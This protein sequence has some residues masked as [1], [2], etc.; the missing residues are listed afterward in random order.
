MAS[1]TGTDWVE[2]LED[3][4][5]GSDDPARALERVL[6][7]PMIAFML[8]FANALEAV[9]DLFIVPVRSLLDGIDALLGA[10]FGSGAT[11]AADVISAGAQE[12]IRSLRDGPFSVLSFN[13]GV[14]VVLLSG[15]IIAYYL[16]R[17]STSDLV[18]FTFT[19][20]P[21]IGTDEE[22]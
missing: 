18:P 11:G 2:R 19:D 10:L 9:L 21:I 12:T 14:I 8:Q 22:N 3:L 4:Q 17:E 16:Q 13:V 7:L 15:V 6:L 20:F 5:G 1:G